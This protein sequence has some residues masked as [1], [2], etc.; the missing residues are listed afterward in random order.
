[1]LILVA[2]NALLTCIHI[3][4]LRDSIYGE[5]EVVHKNAYAASAKKAANQKSNRPKLYC[6]EEQT[7]SNS[8]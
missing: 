7:Q 4:N 6:I 3:N 2:F 8:D 5:A 1:M